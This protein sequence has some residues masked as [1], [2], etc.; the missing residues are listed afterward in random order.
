LRWPRATP[1][2]VLGI[3]V[4]Q[5]LQARASITALR[6]RV[7]DDITDRRAEDRVGGSGVPWR[8]GGIARLA[9]RLDNTYAR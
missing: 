1:A 6:L 7:V 3:T 4:D 2:L 9:V 8:R 5:P